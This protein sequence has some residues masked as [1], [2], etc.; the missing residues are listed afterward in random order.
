MTVDVLVWPNITYGRNL[1][2]DSYVCDLRSLLPRITRALPDYRFTLA[3]PAEVESLRMPGVSFAELPLPTY[4]NTMRT[5]FDARRA[6]DII[7]WKHRS[8]DIVWSHLPE[9]T[10]ALRNVFANA[11]DERPVFVGYSHWFEVPELNTLG[12]TMFPVAMAGIA[13]MDFCGVTTGAVKSVVL[14]RAREVFA[15]SFVDRLDRIIR[16]QYLGVEPAPDV[17]HVRQDER[18]LLVWNHRPH[19]Y[20]GFP[21]V[22]EALDM[23]WGER[24]DWRAVCTLEDAWSDRPWAVPSGLPPASDP[25]YRRAYF[26]LLASGYAGL[27]RLVSHWT[28]PVA[29]ADGMSVG[30][31]YVVPVDFYGTEV[32]RREYPW[33]YGGTPDVPSNIMSALDVALSSAGS[34]GRVIAATMS[35]ELAR[36]TSWDARVGPFIRMFPWALDRAPRMGDRSKRY[37]GVLKAAR[38]G[39]TKAEL[40]KHMGWGVGIPWTPYRQR[41]RDDGVDMTATDYGGAGTDGTL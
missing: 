1:E 8:W 34:V 4:P 40:K 10:L 18:R 38:S 36:A 19:A 33:L 31:P 41:L 23:L 27:P 26:E 3:L 28:W 15:P 39:M 25:G 22:T 35:R 14:D 12:A 6:L 11:T 21:V 37:P 17:S 16:P 30:L 5:H 7:D 24:Q 29:I 32:Y 2:A 9:H 20:T 13:E